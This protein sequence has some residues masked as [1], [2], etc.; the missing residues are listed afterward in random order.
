MS[1]PLLRLPLLASINVIKNISVTQITNLI[2]TSSKVH[3]L[4][5][6]SKYPV[7]LYVGP[8]SIRLKHPM[9]PEKLRVLIVGRSQL[10]GDQKPIRFL[11]N[12]NQGVF[13][14]WNDEM[15]GYRRIIDYLVGNFTVK[16][17]SFE[18]IRYDF[19][20]F[21]EYVEYSKSR[22]IK[23]DK[24]C[25]WD[26]RGKE[27]IAERVLSACSKASKLDVRLNFTPNFTFNGFH[28]FKMDKLDI[29]LM[30]SEWFTVDHMC[31]LMNCS[32]VIIK[33]LMYWKAVDFN[34]FLKF[35]I[36]S[37]GRL[38][39]VYLI[40][41]YSKFNPEIVMNG[42]NNIELERNR[43]FQIQKDNGLKAEVTVTNFLF[44]LH[45]IES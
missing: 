37:D 27:G 30:G 31:D 24:V 26:S 14:E 21:V 9:N 41:C 28:E 36:Q 32:E 33:N 17:I 43:T 12:Q 39:T 34:K 45:V 5:K 20:E 3:R 6:I 1:F 40:A 18:M 19:G 22:G 38:R 44:S 16:C 8:N 25:I 13:T 23:F 35:W 7:Q 2:H 29:F 15:E 11:Q 10:E 4:V 42:I